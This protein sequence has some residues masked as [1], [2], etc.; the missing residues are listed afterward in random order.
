MTAREAM[1][2][3]Q[4]LLTANPT[5]RDYT[6]PQDVL[7]ALVLCAE[8]ATARVDQRT[9]QERVEYEALLRRAARLVRE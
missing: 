9:L 1:T 8:G 7:A 6:V 4:A 2:A 3:G 5:A